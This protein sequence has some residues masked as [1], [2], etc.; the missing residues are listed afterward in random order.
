MKKILHKILTH[1]SIVKKPPVLVDIGASGDI[2]KKWELIAK[3]SICIAFDAD[4]RDFEVLDSE[5][6]VWKKLYSLNRMVTAQSFDDNDFY[7][8]KS[9]YCSSLLPPDNEALKPWAFSSLFDI[10][11]V[12]KLPSVDLMSVISEVNI[13]YIDWYKTDT[14]GADLRIFDSLS[15]GVKDKIIMAEF[16]PG[17]ID[18][19]KGEDK[20]NHL[21][22]YMDNKPF[23]VSDMVVKGSQRI[24]QEDYKSLNYLQRRGIGSFLKAAPGWC[25]ISYI[26]KMDDNSMTIRDYLL[27]W[28]FSSIE[29]EHGFA[30]HVAKSGYGKFS[31]D[32]FLLLEKKSN[33][34]LHYGYIRFFLKAIKRRL[35]LI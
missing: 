6:K 24:D 17:I 11:T 31:D 8:T 35:S 30:L 4:D 21:M 27:A 10:E 1:S 34:K 16:E 29:G 22:L 9:P 5:S 26:N 7:L 20:L 12:V 19:Y 13:D 14:Q 28:V 3:H 33:H 23:W 2:H 18:A 32:I 25:E 15:N